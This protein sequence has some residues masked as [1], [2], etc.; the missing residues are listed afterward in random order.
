MLERTFFKMKVEA[1]GSSDTLSTPLPDNMAS[2]P[3]R[4]QYLFLIIEG[5]I[6]EIHTKLL[7]V[8]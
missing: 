8:T 3:T 2:H 7:V 4:H 1:G 6:G 5:G